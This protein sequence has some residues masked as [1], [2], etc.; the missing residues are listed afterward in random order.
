MTKGNNY[1]STE[2]KSIF[3]NYL[4]TNLKSILDKI[5]I[6]LCTQVR[7]VA[8]ERERA[9]EENSKFIHIKQHIYVR[10]CELTTCHTRSVFQKLAASSTLN[11]V[12][13]TG[14]PKA[15]DTPEAAPAA[16]KSRIS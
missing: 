1:L 15:A 8:R 4:L 12:P 5:V 16:T 3:N 13:P 10:I 6:H 9:G 11:R 7:S 14:A 2:Q